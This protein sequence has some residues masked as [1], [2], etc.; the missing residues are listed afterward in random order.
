MG[1]LSHIRHKDKQ[2][3]RSSA[4]GFVSGI[5]VS[6]AD[7]QTNSLINHVLSA[8]GLNNVIPTSSRKIERWDTWTSALLSWSALL[9]MLCVALATLSTASILPLSLSSNAP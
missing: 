4:N 6:F 3:S 2:K 7:S 1:R 5:Q 9:L 8:N